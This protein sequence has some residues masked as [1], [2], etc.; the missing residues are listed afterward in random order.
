MRQTTVPEDC[1]EFAN[2]SDSRSCICGWEVPEDA[3]TKKLY[4]HIRRNHIDSKNCSTGIICPICKNPDERYDSLVSHLGKDH[5][6]SRDEINSKYK[7]QLKSDKLKSDQMSGMKSEESIKAKND[8]HKERRIKDDSYYKHKEDLK[9]MSEEEK[10]FSK[11]SG[12][13]RYYSSEENKEALRERAKNM[14]NDSERLK[15][16][17]QSC[18]KTWSSEE[19]SQLRSELNHKQ[20]QEGKYEKRKQSQ[21]EYWNSQKGID[22]A[23]ER[24]YKTNALEQGGKTHSR[25]GYSGVYKNFKFAS[26]GEFKFIKDCEQ[27]KNVIKLEQE[28]VRIKYIDE[29]GITRDYLP[30]FIVTL[31]CGVVKMVEIKD[32]RSIKYNRRTTL[33]MHAGQKFCENNNMIYEIIE[34]GKLFKTRKERKLFIEAARI[35]P[36]LK[37]IDFKRPLKMNSNQF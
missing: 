35:N 18:K 12:L 33:K 17:K 10:R 19:G 25:S 6:L 9:T 37:F 1:I 16:Q 20:K 11:G 4:E 23:R 30:D 8:A 15:R 2:K 32:R 34:G 14:F 3:K 22:S 28:P 21:K 5:L 13:R 27:D 29:N 24:M 36:T 31:S 7:G 26:I